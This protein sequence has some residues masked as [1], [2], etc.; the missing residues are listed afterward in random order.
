MDFDVRSILI[1]VALLG[2]G[3]LFYLNYNQGQAYRQLYQQYQSLRASGGGDCM[4]DDELKKVIQVEV[5]AQLASL[6]TA[7][8]GKTTWG[9][10][11]A[12][13]LAK[14]ESAVDDFSLKFNQAATVLLSRS[15]QGG[16]RG[17]KNSDQKFEEKAIRLKNRIIE[18]CK[19][20]S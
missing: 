17:G 14:L 5:K 15:K 1:V 12:A 8:G 20:K 13:R 11:E 4:D 7:Q 2:S 16:G 19:K 6:P 18:L 10:T 3:Y 9:D